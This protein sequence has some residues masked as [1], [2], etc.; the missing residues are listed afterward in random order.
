MNHIKSYIEKFKTEF[1]QSLELI[2]KYDRI[3]IFRHRVPD[4][5]ALGTQLGLKY[6]LQEVFPNKE[7]LTVGDD[8]N[9]FTP[10]LFEEMD[11]VEDDWFEDPFLAIICDVSD[12]DRVADERVTKAKDSIIFDHHPTKE[13]RG[14]VQIVDHSLA[15]ASELV[16][17]FCLSTGHKLNEA[18]ARNF[19]IALVGDSGRFMYSSVSPFTFSI[20]QELLASGININEIYLN[21]YENSIEDLRVQ[22]YILTHYEL[23]SKGVAY[24]ILKENVMKKLNL[25]Q[26]NAKAFVNTFANIKGIN[27]WCSISE[28]VKDDCWRVSIRSKKVDISGVAHKWQGGG[29][30]QASGARLNH[31]KDLK[32]FIADLDKVIE[33]NL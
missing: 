15:A 9:K 21:M 32:A 22:A 27:V 20:A 11:I 28:D 18:S 25:N 29:H 24:Y 12:P 13:T 23:S 14:T 33:E 10:K 31:I 1:E 4:F 3:V 17:A 5:D 26:M 2:K 7:I 19:Y 30:A 6:F 8:H 16:A